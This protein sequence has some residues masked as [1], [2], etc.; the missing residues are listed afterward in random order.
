MPEYQNTNRH[1]EERNF[2]L[3]VGGSKVLPRQRRTS[4]IMNGSDY[5]AVYTP[6][7]NSSIPVVGPCLI[8]RRGLNKGGYGVFGSDLA[9]RVAYRMARGAI[10]IGKSVLHMCHRRCCVQPAHLY[11]GD[12]KENSK[13]RE[14]R[15][16]ADVRWQGTGFEYESLVKEGM[17]YYWDEPEST[18]PNLLPLSPPPHK[19]TYTIPAVKIKLCQTCFKAEPHTFSELGKIDFQGKEL[20]NREM[21]RSRLDELCVGRGPDGA[22]LNFI[23][24]HGRLVVSQSVQPLTLVDFI[25]TQSTVEIF[26]ERKQEQV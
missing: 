15:Y 9:H 24:S 11:A 18:Q 1:H 2:L 26:Y 13:D 7:H 14:L 6:P 4:G 10:P 20:K 25:T 17:K 5:A 22:P 8:W 16:S 3:W 23:P 19:C 21:I 12:A